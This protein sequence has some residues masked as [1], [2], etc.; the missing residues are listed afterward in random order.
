MKEIE[1]ERKNMAVR[2][3]KEIRTIEQIHVQITSLI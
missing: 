1:N 3:N 2:K